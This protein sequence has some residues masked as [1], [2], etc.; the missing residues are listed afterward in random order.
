MLAALAAGDLP[1]IDAV[2]AAAKLAGR[3]DPRGVAALT[4][5]A[6]HDD[7]LHVRGF[8]AEMLAGLGDPGDL[9]RQAFADTLA[10]LAADPELDLSRVTVAAAL[11][12]LGDPRGAVTLAQLATDPSLR[13]HLRL[14][15]LLKLCDLAPEQAVSAL[16]DVV[17]DPALRFPAVKALARV[18]GLDVSELWAALADAS[19][20]LSPHRIVQVAAEVG[21]RGDPRGIELLKGV[22]AD[23][24]VYDGY[25]LDAAKALADLGDRDAVELLA[26]HT[27]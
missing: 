15:A 23:P 5:R 27:R 14:Q 11:A 9:V 6:L 10:R 8:A 22:V 4:E 1:Y 25:R 20:A 19:A 24:E 16:T 3:G 13:D 21:G 2:S 26:A 7:D 17:G 12:N 18:P